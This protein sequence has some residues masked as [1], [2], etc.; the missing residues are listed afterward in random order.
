MKPPSTTPSYA[1]ARNPKRAVYDRDV[2]HAIL[3]AGLVGHVGFVAGGRP[4]VIPMA[5]AR[6]GEK[7]YL[8]GASKTRIIKDNAGQPMCLTVTLLD[9]L[10]AARS[11]MNHS[12]NY[13]A[14]VVHGQAFAVTDADEHDHALRLITEHL[15]PG[16]YAEIREMTKQE[17]KATGVLELRVEAASAK[18]RTGMPTDEVED[19]ALGIWGGVVS[20]ITAIG[21]GVPDQYTPAGMAEPGSFALAR[22]RFAR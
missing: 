2:V 19:H 1:T 14:A 4:M 5:Y 6:E 20:V 8:H 15:L 16:R 3:D 10:V 18:V 22:Q 13:R 9:G 12:V 17:R 11:G 7:L 21:R